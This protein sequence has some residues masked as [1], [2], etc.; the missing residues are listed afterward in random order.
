MRKLSWIAGLAA[1]VSLH[2]LAQQTYTVNA[3]SKTVSWGYYGS[4]H[5]AMTVHSGDTV[6]DTNA[7]DLRSERT[8]PLSWSQAEDIPSYNDEIYKN[9]PANERGQVVTS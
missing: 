7:F 1:C 5:P 8:A 4:M 2:A 3:T 9:Y 6:D